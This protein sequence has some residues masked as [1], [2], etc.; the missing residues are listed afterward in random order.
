MNIITAHYLDST[1]LSAANRFAMAPIK[2]A[3]TVIPTTIHPIATNFSLFDPGITSPY[4][5]VVI[6]ES[7]QYIAVTYL[8]HIQS[9]LISVNNAK[10]ADCIARS[11]LEIH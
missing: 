4:P 5:T 11:R 10:R 7:D 1:V 6:V 3:K 2:Y 9:W 8:Q